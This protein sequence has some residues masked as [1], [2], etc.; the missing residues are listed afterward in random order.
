[1]LGR[2]LVVV[3]SKMLGNHKKSPASLFNHVLYY[4]VVVV[5]VVVITC[6]LIINAYSASLFEISIV[7]I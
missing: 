3:F 1:M 6:S 5:V 2:S 4:Y 7:I